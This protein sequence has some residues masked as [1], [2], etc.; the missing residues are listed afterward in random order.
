[1]KAENVANALFVNVVVV[2]VILVNSIVTIITIFYC[3]CYI[4]SALQLSM[5]NAICCR[6]LTTQRVFRNLLM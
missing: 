2:V 3:C 4:Y 5:R 1:M 6:S